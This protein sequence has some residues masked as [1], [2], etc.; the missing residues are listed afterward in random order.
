MPT[1]DGLRLN[2]LHRIK[3]ARPNSGHQY[4]QRAVAAEQSEPRRCP[5]Q[6]DGELVAKKQILSLKPAP[7]LEQASDKYSERM[8]DRKQRSQ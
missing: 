2:H 1:Q 5:P 7:R 6:S 4:E 3:K 8:Q